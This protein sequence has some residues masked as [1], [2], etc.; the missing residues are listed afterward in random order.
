MSFIIPGNSPFISLKLTSAGRLSLSQGRLTFSYF[1]LGDSELSYDQLALQDA[2]PLDVTLS[3]SPYVF[4]PMDNQPNIKS[5]LSNNNTDPLNILNQSDIKVIKAVVNNEATERGFFTRTGTTFTTLTGSTYVKGTTT[6]SNSVLTGGTTLQ[7]NT[8]TSSGV[9]RSL[10]DFLLIKLTNDRIGTQSISANTQPIPH[11]WYKV[12]TNN[13]TSIVVDR[14]LPNL[15]G[16]TG[17]TSQILFYN[18]AEVY[19]AFGSG[20]TTS[21]WN[22][23]TLSFDSCCDVSCGDVSIWNMNQ[24]WCENPAGITGSTYE[25]YTKF[26]SYQYLGIKNPYFEYLCESTGTT[27]NFNCNGSGVSYDDEVS[28]SIA[29]F[30]Y[31]NNTISNFYGE[32][33]YID[34]TESKTVKLHFPDLM[35]HRANYATGSGLT[36]GMTFLASGSTKLIGTSQIEYVDLIEDATLIASGYTPLVVGKVFTQLKT[37]VIDDDEIVAALS[38]KGNR[39]WTL[40]QL[41]AVLSSPSGGTS[42]GVLPV[43]DTMYLTYLL[44]NQNYTGLTTSLPC[45]NYIKITN[46]TN[47]AKDVSFKLDDVDLLPY[48]R[49]V[50]SASYDGRGFYAHKFKLLYQIVDEIDDRPLT[51]SWKVY[52]FTTNAITTNTNETINPTLLQNQIPSS[53]GFVV[54]TLIN[55]GAT[56]FDLI[57]L[58]NLA[59]N[60]SPTNLQFGDEKFMYGNLQTYIGATIYKS[61]IGLNINSSFF[62]TTT[63]STRSTDPSTNPATIRISDIGVYDQNKNLVLIGKLA[64]PVKLSSGSNILIE[65]S[66]DF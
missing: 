36:Q 65:L 49:K 41:S 16:D 19:S 60:A 45:Q 33:L 18:S 42:T 20:N 40:P 23:D 1:G 34:N 63:N 46:T 43:G 53:N 12:Q 27:T 7:L 11:L 17:S 37:I 66:L 5:Y 25:D 2:N 58:L 10:G 38:Y 32:L 52:D 56:T 26:G 62:N 30:H 64:T 44:D 31:T 4:R 21:Y 59:P 39:N 22:T 28:K 57:Q 24:V 50:E 13:A 35:Y 29:I 47:G 6:I 48:M 3:G 9:T 55:S 15:S 8:L 51:G 61:L 14:N 54:T